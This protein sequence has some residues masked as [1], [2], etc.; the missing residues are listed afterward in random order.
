MVTS[1]KETHTHLQITKLIPKL[2]VAIIK[3]QEKTTEDDGWLP[4]LRPWTSVQSRSKEFIQ[5][6]RYLKVFRKTQKT[7]LLHISKVSGLIMTTSK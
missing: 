2:S 3:R 6:M 1:K 5:N 7:A 4:Y